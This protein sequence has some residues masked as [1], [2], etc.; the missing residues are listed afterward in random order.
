MIPVGVQ[1][2][3]EHAMI[4]AK[5][6]IDE[7]G[8]DIEIVLAAESEVARDKYNSIQ[9]RDAVKSFKL[10]AHPIVDNPTTQILEKAGLREACEVMIGTAALDW[11]LQGIVLQEIEITRLTVY[12]DGEKYRIKDFT[13]QSRFADSYLYVNLGLAKI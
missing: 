6:L 12:L 2:E 5:N 7:Y 4:D 8:G 3:R 1:L 10:K 13:R 11:R 9:K